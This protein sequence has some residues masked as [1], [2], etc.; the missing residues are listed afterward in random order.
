MVCG[1][2]SEDLPGGGHY[3]R[4]S[5]IDRTRALGA[6]CLLTLLVA[7]NAGCGTAPSS[8]TL[9]GPSPAV[10]EALASGPAT[11]DGRPRDLPSS[12]VLAAGTYANAAFRPPITFT[13][14]DGWT[15]GTRTDGFFDVQQDAGTPDVTALQFA[16]VDGVVGAGGSILPATTADDAIA[17]VHANP[18]LAVIDESPSQL[19]GLEGLN[20]IVENQGDAT[21]SVLRVQP[22]V[23]GFDPGRRL[24]ISMFDTPDGVI[25]VMVGGS[26]AQWERTLK[27]AEPVLESVA[28]DAPPAG[29]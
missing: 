26:V 9:G 6:S 4:A 29:G 8:P 28:I 25:A 7:M 22:G 18:G 3:T 24:W 12:G 27:T 21:S 1:S 15:V 13:I 14:G 19:G 5:V 11:N 17:A 16:R 23:L 20:V 2:L 10:S